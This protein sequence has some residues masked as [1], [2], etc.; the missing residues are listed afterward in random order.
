MPA[1][2]CLF[3]D[4]VNVNCAAARKLGMSAVHYEHNEQAIPEIREALG[5]D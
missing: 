4:D 1:E 5:L 2:E 3:V